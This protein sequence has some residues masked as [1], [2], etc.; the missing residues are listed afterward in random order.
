[1]G[2]RL[3]LRDP[4][5]L[6][7]LLRE[8]PLS[9]GAGSAR[10]TNCR[11]RRGSWMFSSRAARVALVSLLSGS[12]PQPPPPLRCRRL[13]RARGQLLVGGRHQQLHAV[14]LLSPRRVRLPLAR[15]RQRPNT[16]LKFVACSGA[17]TADVM[18][19]QIQSVTPDEHRHDDDRRQ[20][21]R[22]L[23][24]DLQCTLG[25]CSSG[26]RH[27]TRDLNT[28]WRRGSTR[29]TRR[30]GAAHRARRVVVL[31]YPR[32]FSSASCSAPP[33]SQRP[34]ARRRTSSRMRRR[35]TGARAAAYGPHVQSAIAR[36]HRACGLLG[37]R[38]AQR[39][40]SSSTPSESYHPNRNGNSPGY[41]PLVRSV[42]G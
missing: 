37:Q 42:V 5:R 23:E 4:I 30:S 25:S 9:H 15:P 13:C 14:E 22:I 35:L 29:C 7:L 2:R 11:K 36:L 28:T 6:I 20:R 40:Q 3:V 16:S 32:M 34:N 12:P 41:A 38:L 17:T 1:M 31:G 39:P 24:P 27:D 18:P 33:A 10:S 8:R 21:H 26:A 19:S